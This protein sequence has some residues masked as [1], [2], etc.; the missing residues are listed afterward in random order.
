VIHLQI[1]KFKM[2]NNM[3][4]SAHKFVKQGLQFVLTFMGMTMMMRIY[5][6]N[7]WKITSNMLIHNIRIIASNGK[8]L[9]VLI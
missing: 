4:M 9:L 6:F 8:N 1:S 3:M 5:D 7:V 2:V